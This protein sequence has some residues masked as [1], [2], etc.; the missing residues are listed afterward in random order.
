[1]IRFGVLVAF[2]F[3]CQFLLYCQLKLLVTTYQPVSITICWGP[4]IIL[5]EGC[6]YL[7]GFASDAK[8]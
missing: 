6:T 8:T 3:L 2:S 7:N 1:M 5:M 4:Y